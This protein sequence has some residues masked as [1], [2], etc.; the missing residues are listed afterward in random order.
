MEMIFKE[1]LHDAKQ[2]NSLRRLFLSRTQ[3]EKS[4]LRTV[5]EDGLEIG[6]S[7]EP[8]TVLQNGDVIEID[9]I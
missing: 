2:N 1:K 5:T 4:H 8:G 6:L 3:M 9:S 7:L